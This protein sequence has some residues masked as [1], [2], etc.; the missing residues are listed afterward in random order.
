M[1]EA[2]AC[3]SFSLT[4]CQGDILVMLPWLSLFWVGCCLS[5]SSYRFL[6]CYPSDG[7]RSAWGQCS[8]LRALFPH[9]TW[10]SVL[11][12]IFWPTLNF[13][14]LAWVSPN[15][16]ARAI[17]LCRCVC[18]FIGLQ[19]WEKMYCISP[20]FSYLNQKGNVMWLQME[21]RIEYALD[22]LVVCS[23]TVWS[24]LLRV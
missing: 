17:M 15:P 21:T 10:D 18:H 2:A 7:G 12:Y 13:L 5:L 24:V 16:N 1:W 4:G 6:V 22:L 3:S 8:G 9:I 11:Q 14:M 20:V 23:R 19:L